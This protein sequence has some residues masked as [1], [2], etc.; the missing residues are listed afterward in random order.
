MTSPSAR[1]RHFLRNA[2]LA[3][4]PGFAWG[5]ASPVLGQGD[6]KYRVVPGWGLLD[7]STPVK[8][9]HGIVQ[10]REGHV[11]LVTDH[12][13]NNV[14]IYD[15]G[16]KLLHKWGTQFPGAHGLSI[17]TQGAIEVLYPRQVRSHGGHYFVAH[18]AD[19][20]PKDK[21]SRGFLSV[22][23]SEFK[24]LSNIAGTPPVYDNAGKLQPMKHQE[25]VFTH[26]HDLIVGEDGSIYVAQFSSGNTYPIKL[27]RV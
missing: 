3:F 4:V 22:M 7:E 18:L 12:V 13:A 27:E 25:G 11:I 9:C 1:R 6:F 24:V 16:G 8:N 14:I 17:V 21:S 19:N 15:Q 20:W 10:D 5:E 2:A 23:N 26:P